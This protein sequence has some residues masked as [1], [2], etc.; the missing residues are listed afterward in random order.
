MIYLLWGVLNILLI[1]GWI[2]I[3]FSLLFKTKSFQPRHSKLY[4]VVF[5]FGLIGLLAGNKKIEKNETKSHNK[6]VTFSHM[7]VGKTLTHH[8]EILILKDKESNQILPQFT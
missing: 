4:S 6:P 3:G 1:L 8:L 2:W 7:E 5:I